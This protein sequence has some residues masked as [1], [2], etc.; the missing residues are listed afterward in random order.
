MF[1]PSTLSLQ[2][3][4]SFQQPEQGRGF[5]LAVAHLCSAS[6][7]ASGGFLPSVGPRDWWKPVASQRFI[8][9]FNAEGRCSVAAATLRLSWLSSAMRSYAAKR[10][11]AREAVGLFKRA[12]LISS[13]TP[14]RVTPQRFS[15]RKKAVESKALQAVTS[16]SKQSLYRRLQQE[17]A[18]AAWLEEPYACPA[19]QHG[20]WRADKLQRHL[21]KCCPD[22]LPE[23]RHLLMAM[24]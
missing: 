8:A 9:I 15:Y 2:P 6:S 3:S 10:L 4:C 20:S 1:A 5:A 16:P 13:F 12:P 11:L 19:C 23:V 21:Q 22:L 14:P 24:S 17:R 18:G 7:C